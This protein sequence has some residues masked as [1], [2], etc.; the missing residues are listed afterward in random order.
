MTFRLSFPSLPLSLALQVQRLS[1]PGFEH[2]VSYVWSPLCDIFKINTPLLGSKE[3]VICCPQ[4]SVMTEN[5]KPS[6]TWLSSAFSMLIVHFH[7]E[8]IQV[9]FS[10][11]LGFIFVFYK[12]SLTAWDE[13]PLPS[14]H[15]YS[16][17]F[18]HKSY[19]CSASS[20]ALISPYHLLFGFV[21][22]F[23]FMEL[24]QWHNG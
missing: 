7:A 10:R 24:A 3:W 14:L 17:F 20:F 8:G 2:S 16:D 9:T 1:P 5:S 18:P 4:I 21:K 19:P 12:S 23:I 13:L 15:S 11:H 6:P 22:K